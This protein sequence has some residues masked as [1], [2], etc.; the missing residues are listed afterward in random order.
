LQGILDRITLIIKST[1]TSQP[2]ERF[3][4]DLSYMDLSSLP[5]QEQ[6][7]TTTLLNSPTHRQIKLL[8]QAFL[9]RLSALETGLVDNDPDEGQSPFFLF[10]NWADGQTQT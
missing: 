5:T 10:R 9:I 7:E 4:F 1:T 8:F 6:K 2:L 3:L